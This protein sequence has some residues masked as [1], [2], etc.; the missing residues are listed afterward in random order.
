MTEIEKYLAGEMTAKEQA[1]FEAAMEQ[2][3]AL[4][5][6]VRFVR[7]L[8]ED[9]ETAELDKRVKAALH[10]LPPARAERS[11]YRWWP[12]LI[13]AAALLVAALFFLIKRPAPQP[14]PI[15]TPPVDSVQQA[16]PQA[17]TGRPA[18]DETPEKNSTTRP[19]RPV[20]LNQPD[21]NTRTAMP[22]PL[23][24]GNNAAP[25]TGRQALLDAVW[26]SEYPPEWLQLREPF[27]RVD[28]LLR[29]RAFSKS[30]AQLQLLERKMPANDTLFFLKGYCLLE[31][32]EGSEAIRCFDRIKDNNLAGTDLLEWYRGLAYLLSG[33]DAKAKNTFRKISTKPGHALQEQ[34]GRALKLLE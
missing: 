1:A 16:P 21:R 9:I 3:P 5:E 6:A 25:D 11:K 22:A 31:R 34:A 15:E 20:A 4:A 26:Y 18:T 8:T 2:N 7:Q 33:E 14:A 10:N 32:G 13:L 19:D 27:S 24:R 17:G 12:L 28:A 30:Y 29:Q 23:L